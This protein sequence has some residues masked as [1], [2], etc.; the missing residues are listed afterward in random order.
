MNTFITGTEALTLLRQEAAELD[1]Q[2][3][4][5]PE[6]NVLIVDAVHPYEIDLARINDKADLL[7]WLHHM[8]EKNWIKAEHLRR[9]IE[10]VCFIKG[11]SVYK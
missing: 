6:S 5:N 9:I 11:W 1:R 10:H 2:F 7:E 4:F 8:S 3:T